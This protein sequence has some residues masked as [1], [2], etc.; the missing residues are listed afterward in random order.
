MR[1][2]FMQAKKM[3]RSVHCEAFFM[4]MKPSGVAGD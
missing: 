4:T 1:L 2:L 3:P